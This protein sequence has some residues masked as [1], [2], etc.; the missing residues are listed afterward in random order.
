MA[1]QLSDKSDYSKVAIV[2]IALVIA[3]MIIGYSVST[4][5]NYSM[6]YSMGAGAGVAALLG[7]GYYM[8]VKN[9]QNSMDYH[10]ADND[11]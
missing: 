1:F 2:V 4:S 6:W 9:S 11:M 8:Y 3:G 7:V 10:L 5:Y